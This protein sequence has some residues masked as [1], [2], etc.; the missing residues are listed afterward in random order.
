MLNKLLLRVNNYSDWCSD[1][2]V[3]LY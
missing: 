1:N 2:T 3:D